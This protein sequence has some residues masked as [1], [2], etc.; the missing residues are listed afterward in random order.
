MK[1]LLRLYDPTQGQILYA[2]EDIRNLRLA[3]YQQRY[4]VVFQDFAK[5][6][7][8][9]RDNVLLR[10]TTEQDDSVVWDGLRKS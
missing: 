4:S 1:L 8:S 10:P 9:V 2:D 7:L 5:F 3:E 6:S